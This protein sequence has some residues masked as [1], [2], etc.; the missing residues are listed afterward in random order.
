MIEGHRARMHADANKAMDIM[1]AIVGA[2]R[3]YRPTCGTSRE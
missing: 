3:P 1:G 2:N